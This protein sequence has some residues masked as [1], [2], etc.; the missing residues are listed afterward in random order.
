MT[1]KKNVPSFPQWRQWSPPRSIWRPSSCYSRQPWATDSPAV[2]LPSPS[3]WSPSPQCTWSKNYSPFKLQAG[4]TLYKG[5][6]LGLWVWL[7]KY[8][9]VQQRWEARPSTPRKQS[10]SSEGTFFLTTM[11]LLKIK[12]KMFVYNLCSVSVDNL[13][14]DAAFECGPVSCVYFLTNDILFMMWIDQ[15]GAWSMNTPVRQLSEYVSCT[16]CKDK[17]FSH[18]I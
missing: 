12:R 11:L 16:F 1:L 14:M 8:E 13:W 2:H 17:A 4:Y 18:C 15:W 7:T 6:N 3:P 9:T 5:Y 10:D